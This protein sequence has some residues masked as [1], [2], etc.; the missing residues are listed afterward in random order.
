MALYDMATSYSP[1]LAILLAMLYYIHRHT[2][3]LNPDS[4]S[5]FKPQQWAGAQSEREKRFPPTAGQLALGRKFLVKALVAYCVSPSLRRACWYSWVG[6]VSSKRFRTSFC[7]R[8]CRTLGC[9]QTPFRPPLVCRNF[10]EILEDMIFKGKFSLEPF[11][12]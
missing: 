12:S 10:I 4:Y 9:P 7:L 3:H 1:Q 5:P 2:Y 6:N 11:G 8:Y